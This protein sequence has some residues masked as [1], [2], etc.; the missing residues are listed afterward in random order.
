M[1]HE[2]TPNVTEST[3]LELVGKRF[4]DYR[5]LRRLG[6]GAM[7]D[8]Y[9]AVQQSLRRHVAFKVLKRQLVS[10]ENYVRRFYNEAQ[11]AAAL[12][13]A[14]IVQ[15]HEVGRIEGTHFIAQE[16]VRGRNLGQYLSRHG[17]IDAPLAVLIMRQ[18][19]AALQKAEEQGIV[20]RDIKPENIMFSAGGEVKVADFGL[21]RIL[22]DQAMNLTRSGSTM[23]TPLYMSPEQAEGKQLDSRSDVYS[24]GVTCY[25][26]LTGEAPFTGDTPVSVALQHIQVEPRPLKNLRKDLPPELC[27]VVHKMMAKNPGERYQ[28]P[29]DLLTELRALRLETSKVQWPEVSDEWSTQEASVM[30]TARIEATQRLDSLMKTSV[31]GAG[32]LAQRYGIWLLFVSAALAAFVV[33]AIGGNRF[34]EGDLLALSRAERWEGIAR[35]DTAEQ[36]L[37]DAYRVNTERA[38]QSVWKFHPEQEYYE[39]LAKMHLAWL[40][41][42]PEY[43][44]PQQ[45]LM[46]FDELADLTDAKDTEFRAEGLVGQAVVYHLNGEYKR[47]RS[48]LADLDRAHLANRLR[49]QVAREKHR[50]QA[51]LRHQ[52]K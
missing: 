17:P 35:Y 3:E 49:P 50:L 1:P 2:S 51:A 48:L 16:Y 8:V 45:A 28:K 46:L 15:I 44:F 40:Y 52:E 30:S 9:L 31:N 25:H 20:H 29:G 32:P 39:H 42:Q 47:S 14:N 34:R 21:A 33:G 19:A 38:Y 11:A 13:H 10:D 36:Q 26:M 41:L 43:E 4:G 12:V 18:V 27:Q 23:G 24:F 6:Q 5:I 22:D 7:A 37:R